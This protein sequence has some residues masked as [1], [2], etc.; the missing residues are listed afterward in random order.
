MSDEVNQMNSESARMVFNT[1]LWESFVH[2]LGV[3]RDKESEWAMFHDTI[4]WSY[5]LIKQ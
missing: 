4:M 1:H 3:V 2:L 5:C